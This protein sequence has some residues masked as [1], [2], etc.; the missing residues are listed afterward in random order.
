[1]ATTADLA[2]KLLHDAA[3]FFRSVGEQNPQLQQQMNDNAQV[4]DQVAEMLAQDPTAELP[5][6]EEQ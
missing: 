4:Y 1:M 5:L 6:Q 2:A 3:G